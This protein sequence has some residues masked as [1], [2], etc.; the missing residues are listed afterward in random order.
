[1]E[2]AHAGALLREARHRHGVGQEGLAIRAGLPQAVIAEIESG[3]RLPAVQDLRDLLQLL[4]EDL[5]LTSLKRETGIDLTLNQGNLE[6]STDQRVQR[7]MEFADF[8]RQNRSGSAEDLGRSLQPGSLLQPLVNRDVDFVVVGSV[9]GLVYGSAYPTY[10]LDVAYSKESEN[11]ERLTAALDDLGVPL[12]ARLLDDETDVFSFD[13]RFG[14]LDVL[15]EIAGVGR[16]E[17][18]R[19]DARRESIDGLL[20]QV[21]SLDHLISMKRASNKR[22]DQLMAMEYVELADLWRREEER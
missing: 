14:T 17:E 19:R 3:R 5:I 18:L 20:I 8:V 16:Y 11:M 10:D 9:A 1:M 4:G 21:A 22:K 13:T 2:E 6:L 15:G 12:E 7:G